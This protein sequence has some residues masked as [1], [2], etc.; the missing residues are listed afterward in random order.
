MTHSPSDLGCGGRELWNGVT[1]RHE[2]DHM[3][4]V[5]L[6]QACRQRD[7]CDALAGDASNGDLGA[8]RHERD[9]AMAMTRLLSALRLPDG[10]GRKPQAR[11][12]R[13]VQAPSSPLSA[14]ERDR[15]RHAAQ[16]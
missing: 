7:R 4:L 3:Q 12:I 14:L 16:Q 1:E 15:L 2:L 13:G 6:E 5:M 10:A 9:S 8:L 11:Q